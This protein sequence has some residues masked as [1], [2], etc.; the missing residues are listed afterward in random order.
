MSRSQFR[1]SSADR[2]CWPLPHTSRYRS[3]SD[4]PHIWSLRRTDKFPRNPVPCR[5][6]W[7]RCRSHPPGLF[8]LSRRLCSTQT[9]GF[10]PVHMRQRLPAF[11]PI[12]LWRSP[13]GSTHSSP[14][15]RRQ[16]SRFPGRTRPHTAARTPAA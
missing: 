4:P 11:Q 5:T 1:S 10:L 3:Y 16:A 15:A 2:N 13:H 12:W 8:R 6:I 7:T 9:H 14:A